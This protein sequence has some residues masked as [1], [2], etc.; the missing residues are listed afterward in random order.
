MPHVTE[1][2]WTH[3]PARERRLIVSPW[4]GPE[5]QYADADGALDGVRAAAAIWRRS[6]VRVRLDGDEER[7]FRAV[8]RPGEGNGSGD[9]D[10]EI[11]R[12]RKEVE[13]ARGMLGNERFVENAPAEVVAAERE[14]LEGY[15]R[16]LDAL[17]R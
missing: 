8:V 15:L 5:P 6:G 12:L 17:E 1:E 9:R 2:I 7:I 13:R 16:E 10:A 11:A 14:K 4:P 3:L